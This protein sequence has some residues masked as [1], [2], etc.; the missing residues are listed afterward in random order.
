MGRVADKLAAG[1]LPHDGDIEG[2]TD[3][4][5]LYTGERTMKVATAARLVG[6]AEGAT[7]GEVLAK[8]GALRAAAEAP[9]YDGATLAA[10]EIGRQ[11]GVSK[12]RV[13]KEC[14]AML[15]EE[16]GAMLV[17]VKATG[18][19]ETSGANVATQ[20][21]AIAFLLS[22]PVLQQQALRQEFSDPLAMASAARSRGL[23]PLVRA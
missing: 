16:H 9:Q 19:A 2:I 20:T 15:T 21:D 7:G 6:L 13:L 3:I 4:E 1:V 17:Q 5:D 10:I 23:Q 12:A 11:L 18:T 14:A 22:L 8:V